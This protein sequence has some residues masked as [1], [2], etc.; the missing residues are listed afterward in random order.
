MQVEFHPI[1][2]V[3]SL[4]DGRKFEELT[5]DIRTHGLRES[6]MLFS[7]G[8]ILDG[9][10]RYRARIEAGVDARFETYRDKDPSFVRFFR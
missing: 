7:D 8:R 1:A 6:I 10:N 2:N 5:D 9:R 4:I 3:F